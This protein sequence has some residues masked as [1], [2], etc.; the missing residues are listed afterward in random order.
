[1]RVA[2]ARAYFPPLNRKKADTAPAKMGLRESLRLLIA[3]QIIH[4]GK[5][6]HFLAYKTPDEKRKKETM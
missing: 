3:S 4:A 2:A 5:G 6:A 1:M